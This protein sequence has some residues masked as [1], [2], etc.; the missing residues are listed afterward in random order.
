MLLHLPGDR[1]A[2]TVATAMTAKI[3]EFPEIIWRSMTWDQGSEMALHTAITEA[4]GL[5]T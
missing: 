2:A 1:T 4:T 5:P 3:P